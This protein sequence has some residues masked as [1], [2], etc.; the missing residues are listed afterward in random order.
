MPV[1]YSTI[2]K[3]E[4]RSKDRRVAES[5]PNIFYKLKKLQIKQIQD[6]ARISLR[7]CKTKGK[8]YTAGELKSDD[9][10]SK[11]IN[12]DEGYR[13]LRNLRGSPPYFEK[14]KKDLFAMIRQL[15]NPTWFCS[16]SAAE[17]R[18]S[19][20][21]RILG[22]VVHQRDYSDNEIANMSWQEKS[23]LIQK[24]PVTCARNFEHM[25]QLFIKDV[26]KSTAMPLG[27]IAD[28]F[29]RVEFQQ[30]GSPHIH[31]LFW[32]K[33]APAYG[34]APDD[35]VVHFVDK[36]ATCKNSQS[37]EMKDLVNL[38]LHRHAKTCKKLG[39]NV[40]RFNFPLPPMKETVILQPLDEFMHEESQLKITKDNYTKVKELL[41]DMKYGEDITFHQFLEKLELSECDYITAIKYSLKRPTLLLKR[42]PSE[43]RV[44]NYN[45][46]LLKAWQGNMDVQFVR[47]P[48]AC[49]VYILSYI[50]KGQ[51]G[52]SKLLDKASKEA[53]SGNKDIVNRVR[54]I[55]NAFLNAAEISAHARSSL[56][57]FTN[58]FEKIF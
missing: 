33:G 9:Y 24:D 4:L 7:K 39:H 22:R 36:Y 28:Y 43:I 54:H 58:A 44:N 27:E 20:L 37:D 34:R 18:W 45:T 8:I 53:N 50:T 14:S 32:V 21:L 38:Q 11:L 3:W 51:R 15:G 47:D 35:T 56:S 16:F 1:S 42:S 12:L 52:I 29:Y 48:Y 40:C 41:D 5:V 10:L 2:C 19:H 13:V 26:L 17:T 25:V 49:A 6:T 46:N 23:D 57:S 55:G 30:R 31:A